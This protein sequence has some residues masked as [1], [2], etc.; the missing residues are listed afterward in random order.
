MAN[1]VKLPE[2]AEIQG[3]LNW[4]NGQTKCS[5]E[6]GRILFET[7]FR[8][9]IEDDKN[10]AEDGL[11][12]RDRYAEDIGSGLSDVQRDRIR[13]TIHGK[14]SCYEVILS[15]AEDINAMVN[16]EEES[17]TAEFFGILLKNLG[18]DGY[19]EEDLDYR[20]ESARNEIEK[21]LKKW[22]DREYEN[23]DKNCIFPLTKVSHCDKK[24]S[25]TTPLWMQMNK[26][27]EAHSDE[28]GCFVTENCHSVTV[29]K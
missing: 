18:L 29:L 9:S 25:Q 5:P 19:D 4:L 7:E 6:V 12:W 10:R 27:V 1:Q 28:N 3:Y 23:C 24:V 21:I 11:K 17:R 8:W 15:L 26:W 2:V 13:K 14:T 22:M 20:G 16:E